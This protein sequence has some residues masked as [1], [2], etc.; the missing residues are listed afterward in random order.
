MERRGQRVVQPARRFSHLLIGLLHDGP[1]PTAAA[2]TWCRPK[3]VENV[4]LA[5]RSRWPRQR[6][7]HVPDI[8]ALE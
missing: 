1:G 7:A 8:V 2:A 3:A 5:D 4:V 6:T